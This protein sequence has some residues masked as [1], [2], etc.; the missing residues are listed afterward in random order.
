MGTNGGDASVSDYVK[1]VDAELDA[2]VRT[3]IEAAI[4]GIDACEAPFVNNRTS[5]R[6]K[7]AVGTCNDLVDQIERAQQA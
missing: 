1:A 6:W 7:A 4:D 3:A 5:T 2:S